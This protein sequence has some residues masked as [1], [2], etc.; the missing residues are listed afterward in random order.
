MGWGSKGPVEGTSLE[1]VPPSRTFFR[2]LSSPQAGAGSWQSVTKAPFLLQA[3]VF[4]VLGYNP[5]ALGV[6]GKGVLIEPDTAYMM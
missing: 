1:S 5:L 2:D 3:G 6:G 4:I